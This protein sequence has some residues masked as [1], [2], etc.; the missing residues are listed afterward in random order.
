MMFK[1]KKKMEIKE[2]LVRMGEKAR[3]ASKILANLSSEEKNKAL[4]EMALNIEKNAQKIKEENIK[5]IEQARKKGLSSALIDRL[6][7]TDKR[8]A[9]TSKGL[10]EIASL[11]DPVG[12]IESMWKRPNGLFIGKMV[13]P[14]G[15]IG[16][17]YESRP[18]VTVDAAGLCLKAG[19]AVLL[20]GGSEAIRSNCILVDILQEALGRTKVPPESIQLIR[21][22]S[23]EAVTLML[24]LDE[25]IDVIIPRGGES[26]IRTVVENSTIPVIKHYKGV[27]HTFIDSEADLKMA[28][29]ICF[30]AKVQRPGVCNAMETLLVDKEIAKSFLPGMIQKFKQAGVEIRGD[31]KVREIAPEV[32]LATEQD[33]FTEYLD[34]ILSIKVVEGLDEAINHI[35]HYGSHHSDAIVT[36]NY[37]KAK[38]F[39]QEVDSA[40][41]Y[42]NASTRFTDGGE[43]GMGAEIGISTQKLHARGP[44]GVKELTSHKFIILGEGQIRK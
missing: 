25:Y 5:D 26:L 18:N 3:E 21:T 16:I 35:N 15:V 12:K 41:V 17:I 24:K 38:K 8:I 34:L 22:T 28:E 11:E 44:M 36:K 6:T 9:A 33:W 42:V 30:N 31:E 32:K 13:V 20:R 1:E 43:F 37:L 14:L 2:E 19:N 10:R 7:L 40:A 23:R 39:L 27:C 29:D 4:E